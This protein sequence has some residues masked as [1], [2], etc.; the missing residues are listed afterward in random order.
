MVKITLAYYVGLFCFFTALAA[1][2]YRGNAS[3]TEFRVR[4][5]IGNVMAKIR[6]GGPVTIAYFG[7]S[8]TQMDGWRR[9]SLEWLKNRYPKCSFAE[10]NAAIGGTGSDLGVYRYRQD[11]LDFRPDLVFVEFATND[12]GC[13]PETIWKNFEGIVRQTWEANPH[14]DIVFV[15]TITA[16]MMGDYG[17]GKC[18]QAASAMEQL[19]DHFWIPSV[20]FGPRVAA[21]ATNGVLVMS[22][23]ELETAVPKA[24][25]DR[26]RV[27]AE[28]LKAEGKTLFAKDGVHPALP[29][30]GYYL[31]SIKAA[32]AKMENLNTGSHAEKLSRIFFRTDMEQAKMVSPS[33]AIMIGDWRALESN[34]PQGW[35][36]N[37]FGC[38]PYIATEPGSK[39]RFR[40]R[41]M[42]CKIYDLVGPACGQVW[43]TV[44][45]KRRNKPIPRFD[46]YCTYYR[47]SSLDVYD[48]A[49][50]VHEVELEL[51][52]NQ[53][54]RRPVAFRL[55]NPD[56]EL[57]SSKYNGKEWYVGR[58]MLVGDL[59]PGGD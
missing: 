42:R 39:L 9:L 4:G 34:E 27:I 57:A 24:T 43:V 37:R 8:I 21:A 6:S 40:F 41:G 55:K 11:V 31:D 28:K 12:S 19:A 51:D 3:S 35:T 22:I 1:P 10:V 49:D 38:K 26:D 45:G 36:A 29:G 53:P 18:P 56:E 52:A 23:G 32:W 25:P 58:L 5:G 44:D 48:G 2:T 13:S 30:H 20:D 7:G 59:L 47:L 14:T 54:S 15:Y 17:K 50:G 46:G 16:K 33:K